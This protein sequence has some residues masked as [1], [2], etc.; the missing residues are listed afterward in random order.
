MYRSFNDISPRF[1]FAATLTPRTVLRGGFG[2]SFFP[3]VAGNSQGMRNGNFVSTL[4]YTTTPATVVNRL[5]S[6][7]PFPVAD[8]PLNPTDKVLCGRGL[9]GRTDVIGL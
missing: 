9:L 8:N 7:L 3:P 5:S 6:G 1:G 2:I 4:N